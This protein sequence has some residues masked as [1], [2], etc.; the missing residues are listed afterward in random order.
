[1]GVFPYKTQS[2]ALAG[3]AFEPDEEKQGYKTL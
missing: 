2:G 3:G 1:M